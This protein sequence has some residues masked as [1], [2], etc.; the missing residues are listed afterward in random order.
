MTVERIIKGWSTPQ[1]DE[2]FRREYEAL[3]KISID[4]AVMEKAKNVLVVEGDY[5]STV[6]P[7]LNLAPRGILVKWVPQKEG[8]LDL[9]TLEA[10]LHPRQR[11]AAARSG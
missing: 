9:A 7:W 5:P 4:F 3:S 10:H 1:R 2:V 6:Y 8:G 11:S